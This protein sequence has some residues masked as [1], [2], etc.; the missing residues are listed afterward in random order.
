MN[1]NIFIAPCRGCGENVLVWDGSPDAIC[2]RCQQREEQQRGLGK[3]RGLGTWAV[4]RGVD[5]KVV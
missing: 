2:H 1:E 5:I 4:D 3:Y